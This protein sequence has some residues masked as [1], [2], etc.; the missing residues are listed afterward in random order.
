MQLKNNKINKIK[1]NKAVKF[2]L[3]IN[4]NTLLTVHIYTYLVRKKLYF[5]SSFLDLIRS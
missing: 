2:K 4:K 3:N 1:A 5:Y